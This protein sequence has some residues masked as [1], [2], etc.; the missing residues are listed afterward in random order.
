MKGFFNESKCKGFTLIELLVVI[1]IIAILAAILFPVFA[2]A[3]E[4]ARMTTCLSNMKQIG[5]GVMMYV[6]DYDEKY[7]MA[8]YGTPWRGAAYGYAAY[9][10]NT[11]DSSLPSYHMSSWDDIGPEAN[12]MTWQDSISPYIKSWRIFKCP[13]A[14]NFD[15][16]TY[17]IN[18]MITGFFRGAAGKDFSINNPYTLSEVNAPADKILIHEYR[19]R[20]QA[21]PYYCYLWYNDPGAK[22]WIAPHMDGT[23]MTFADG[24][25]KYVKGRSAEYYVVPADQSE[26]GWFKSNPHWNPE[27]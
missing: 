9:S 13:S 5:L 6:E 19:Y 11:T 10:Y 22:S 27:Y 20:A 12:V 4:K 2:Q 24:H 26:W 25:A 15:Y 7:P 21:I 23:N 16:V 17:G 18:A 1:A 8:M 14:A 3:R